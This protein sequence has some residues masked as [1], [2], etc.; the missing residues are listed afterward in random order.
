MTPIFPLQIPAGFGWLALAFFLS[1]AV[2]AF[3]T[4]V[5]VLTALQSF[6]G[7][8]SWGEVERTERADRSPR[9]GPEE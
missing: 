9:T 6:F 2:V 4:Y 3:G 8:S 7:A 5:G 1:A